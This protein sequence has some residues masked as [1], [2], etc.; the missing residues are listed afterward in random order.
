MKTAEKWALFLTIQI[1]EY[2][3]IGVPG[4][5]PMSPHY[6]SYRNISTSPH[7]AG[8]RQSGSLLTMKMTLKI[9][10]IAMSVGLAVFLGTPVKAAPELQNRDSAFSLLITAFGEVQSS[11][12]ENDYEARLQAAQ[13]IADYPERRRVQELASQERDLRLKNLNRKLAELSV[14]YVHARQ[15]GPDEEASGPVPPTKLDMGTAHEK[16]KQFVI[17][18][19]GE[20]VPE[21]EANGTMVEGS[22]SA[23][24]QTE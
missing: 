12:I 8:P 21:N 13:L 16:L 9:L 3:A 4:Y 2:W 6:F 15:S 7:C 22:T 11:M 18:G 10:L 20:I 17:I 23:P 1:H 19:A 5:P 14:A 24:R